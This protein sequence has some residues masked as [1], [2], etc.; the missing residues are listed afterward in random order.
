VQLATAPNPG[1][2]PGGQDAAR[3]QIRGSSL[4]LSGRLLSLGVNFA[5]QVCVVRYLSTSAYGA[6]A[7]GLAVVAF[8]RLFAT[9]GLHEAVPRFV[10]IY[11]ENREYGKLFGTICLAVSAV[12]LVAVVLAAGVQQLFSHY[13]LKEKLTVTLLSILVVLIPI[14]AAD[15]LLDGLFAS[16]A[17][18]RDIFVRKY[19]LGPGL[20][21][22]AV[23]AL[24][25]SHSSVVFLAYGLVTSS[26]LGVLLYSVLLLRLLGE[27]RLLPHF[28]LRSIEVPA[29][30]V[31]AF[32]VPGITATLALAAI[33]SINIFLLGWLR[34]LSDVAYYRAAVPVAELN[35]IVLTSFSL[36]YIPCAARLFARS[37]YVDLSK[38]YWKTS[39]WMSVLS[40][41]IFAATF[42]FG[43]PVSIFLYGARYA[44]SGPV[45]S[46]LALGSYV[47]VV[48]GFN[49]QTLKVLEKLRY[50]IVMSIVAIAMNIAFG[51]L[52]IPRYGAGGAAAG[53]AISV[54]AYNILLQ[55]GL[56]TSHLSIF[57]RQYSSIYITIA[58]SVAALCVIQWLNSLTFWTALPLAAVASLLVLTITKRKLTIA[59]IFPEL[60]RVPLM[61]SIVA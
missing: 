20:K 52:L 32:V 18:T 3:H 8:L 15:G 58:V 27:Q 14:E 46:L 30:E 50:I 11:R 41:P 43:R 34:T 19:V 59:E 45:L 1:Q 26:A 36:L 42:V 6:L 31:L 47:N 56:R 7:Y 35:G 49:L 48:L 9:L 2:N 53:A 29:S 4:L 25:W 44:A 5:S 12:L 16:L 57:D 33:P 17:G 61:K 55:L 23:L 28:S 39:A 22:A 37:N 24:I 21:L 51:L 54:I 13:F 60:L 40:F 10:P 38:L